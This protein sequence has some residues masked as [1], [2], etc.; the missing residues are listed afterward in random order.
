LSGRLQRL[1]GDDPTR[2]VTASGLTT[3]G[4]DSP[5]PIIT[6]AG[7]DRFGDGLVDGLKVAA[8]RIKLFAC[9][10]PHRLVLFMCRVEPG[11]QEIRVA[12]VAADV[13]WRP[14]AFAR[15]AARIF[16]PILDFGATQ[17]QL[18]L[19]VIAKIILVRDSERRVSFGLSDP[20]IDLGSL[21]NPRS[22]IRIFDASGAP[23]V[24]PP[25]WN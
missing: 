12:G 25:T 1:G 6:T 4:S 18:V 15:D 22:T 3:N 5:S 2:A 21:K 24:S 16:D 13:F 9:P 20:S 10:T 23:I 7:T 14:C 17:K 8:F 11:L 19:P